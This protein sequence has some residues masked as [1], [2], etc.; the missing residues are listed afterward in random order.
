MSILESFSEPGA[1]SSQFVEAFQRNCPTG[2]SLSARAF[3]LVQPQSK[4]YFCFSETE[5]VVYSSPSCPERGAL[6]N[7]IDVGRDAVDA[8]SALEAGFVQTYQRPNGVTWR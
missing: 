8:E 1:R 3:C 4:K 2:K 6:R 5:S 7:V